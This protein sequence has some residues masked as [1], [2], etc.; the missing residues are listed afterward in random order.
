VGEDS[1]HPQ[2]AVL[3]VDED[4]EYCAFVSEHLSRAGYAS[5]RVSTAAAA[6]DLVGREQPAAVL[7]EVNLPEV[8]GY[9]VC[10]ELRQR[11]GDGLPIVF[12]SGDRT[13][14]AD[15]VAGLLVGAD[16]YVL[17]PTDPDEL[18]ARVRRLLARAAPAEEVPGRGLP[19]L[20]KRE[21]E[22]LRLLADGLDQNA[23]AGQL[24]ISCATVATHIQRIL[25]KLGVHSRA[26]AVA[27]AYREGLA[28]Q[29]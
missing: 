29:A 2:P 16:D 7:L 24:V 21:L 28:P 12:V 19:E 26:Q 4:E 25:A 15:R 9:E 10:H 8:C 20:T 22:V 18:I 6:I 17:K 27:L 1:S 5:R 3:I 14:P 11:H 13:E 23:I